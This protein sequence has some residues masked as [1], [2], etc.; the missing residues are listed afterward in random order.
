MA[1]FAQS[2]TDSVLKL[3]DDAIKKRAQFAETKEFALTA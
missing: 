1:L 2:R 3:L